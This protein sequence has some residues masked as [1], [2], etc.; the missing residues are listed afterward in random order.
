MLL[1]MEAVVDEPRSAVAR[2]EGFATIGDR[3]L[4]G[5]LHLNGRATKT[6]VGPV[7]C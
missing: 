7:A 3:L 2:N 1:S 5:V 4:S 6:A